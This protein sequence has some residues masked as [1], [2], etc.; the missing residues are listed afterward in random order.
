MNENK[1]SFQLLAF[2]S[3]NK[4][5]QN[6]FSSFRDKHSDCKKELLESLWDLEAET[7]VENTLR[8]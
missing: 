2:T 3:H 5:H 6:Q 4:L 1:I 7:H 8:N